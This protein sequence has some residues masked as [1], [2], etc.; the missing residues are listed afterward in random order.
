[1]PN[2]NAKIKCTVIKQVHL[3]DCSEEEANDEEKLWDFSDD[4][5]EIE[6]VDWELIDL[7]EDK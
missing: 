6:Q 7:E 1:M 3:S 5:I 4:E 2:W